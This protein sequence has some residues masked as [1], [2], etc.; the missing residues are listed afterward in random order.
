MTTTVLECYLGIVAGDEEEKK[1]TV[2][3]KAVIN[4]AVHA[5]RPNARPPYMD[6]CREWSGYLL[7]VPDQGHQLLGPIFAASPNV[8][9][10]LGRRAP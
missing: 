2:V 10:Q 9:S 3:E 5:G 1:K 8:R 4:E 6:G 7:Y